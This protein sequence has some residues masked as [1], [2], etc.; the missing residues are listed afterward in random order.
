MGTAG[1][2]SYESG[3]GA[4]TLVLGES[5]GDPNNLGD[6]GMKGLHSEYLVFLSITRIFI[7]DTYYLPRNHFLT[8]SLGLPKCVGSLRP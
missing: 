8:A 5:L 7:Y 3:T 2:V 1:D 4:P 6:K